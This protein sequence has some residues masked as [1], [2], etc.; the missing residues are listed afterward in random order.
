MRKIAK[1]M[2]CGIICQRGIPACIMARHR[3]TDTDPV[4][5]ILPIFYAASSCE[6]QDYT[7]PPDLA[8]FA[9]LLESMKAKY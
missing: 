8:L 9:E 1:A 4:R 5:E 6:S 3:K 2:D 7:T